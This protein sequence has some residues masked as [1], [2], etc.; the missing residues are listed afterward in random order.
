MSGYEFEFVLSPLSAGGVGMFISD[1]FNYKIIEKT[2]TKAFQALWIEFLFEKKS[3][4]ICGVIYRQHNSPES[5]RAYFD[6][7]SWSKASGKCT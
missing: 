4:I 1:Q 7:N 3:N 5:F 6:E 2:S